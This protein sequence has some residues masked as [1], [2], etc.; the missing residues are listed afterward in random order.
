MSCSSS[1][2]ESQ[3]GKFD[4]GKLDKVIE[5]LD[6]LSRADQVH[7]RDRQILGRDMQDASS[8]PVQPRRVRRL[9]RLWRSPQRRL[10]PRR[11]AVVDV[12]VIRWRRARISAAAAGITSIGAT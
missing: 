6:H 5:D 3:Q 2:I 10:Q 7:P 1:T 8:L 11:V 12:S 4:T 9:W